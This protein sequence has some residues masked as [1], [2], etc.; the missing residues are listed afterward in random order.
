[1]KGIFGTAVAVAYSCCVFAAPKAAK[2]APSD[3]TLPPVFSDHMVVQQGT[4][5]PIWGVGPNHQYRVSCRLGDTVTWTQT[6]SGMKTEKGWDM[7]IYLP[8]MK[9]GGPYELVLSN[10]VRHTTHVIHDV[11]VGEVWLASGQS[12]MAFGMKQTKNALPE[13]NIEKLRI[14]NGS[15]WI[16]AGS[17]SVENLSAV[18]TFFGRELQRELGCAV[19][20]LSLSVGGTL[21]ETW[22]SRAA[23][24]DCPTTRA[25]VDEYEK[26]LSDPETWEPFPPLPKE[27]TP[28]AGPAPETAGWA[29]PGLA[30]DGWT[31]ADL[32]GSFED[33]FGRHFNGAAWFRKTVD[34]PAEWEGKDLVLRTP[35]IE[36]HD[37][38]WFEGEEIGRTGSGGDWTIAD[39]KRVYTVPG[40]LVKSGRRTVA[41]RIWSFIRSAGFR[42]SAAPFTLGPKDADPISLEGEWLARVERDIGN[43]KEFRVKR[44]PYGDGYTFTIP[45]SRYNHLIAP[46]V[47]YA[48][49]GAVWYQGESNADTMRKARDYATTLSALIADWRHQWGIG[50][51]PFGI[52]Q[53]AN[54]MCASTHTRNC[55]WAELRDCQMRVSRE[56]KNTGLVSAID[57]GERCNVH[58]HNKLDVGRRLCRWALS[59]AYGRDVG[60]PATGPRFLS[61][62]VEAGGKV[63]I[64][65][66]EAEGGIEAKG[67]VTGCVMC[68]ADGVWHPAEVAI[69]GETV[70][71]SSP[72]VG[73]PCGI[74]YAWAQYPVGA[75]LVGKG[76]GIPVFP[77]QWKRGQ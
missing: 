8:P 52:V 3:F 17:N 19:G 11:Y 25:W 51:F 10:Q 68:G 15:K 1:M 33:F 40:R 61:G 63:R 7:K 60:G 62:A 26:G 35:G 64:R 46:V 28:D 6:Y 44:R 24:K 38:V 13:Q 73:E 20:I 42:P 31:V 39:R 14:F 49:K 75:T 27:A 72:K 66:T 4:I 59:E 55:P 47:S 30:A 53:L 9:A 57:L 23:L 58:A 18:A 34:I 76:S 50:D 48:M 74:R 41:L 71:V 2:P 21:A 36:Q 65:F 32:P 29:K 56:V 16:V 22:M 67:P 54:F 12:N 77:F 5:V 45:S 70:V 37:I 43:M 69:D